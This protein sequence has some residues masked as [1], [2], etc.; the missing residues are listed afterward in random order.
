MTTQAEL[1]EATSKYLTPNHG[2]RLLGMVRGQGSRIWDA[3]GK[4]YLDFFVGFG[5]GGVGGHCHPKIAEAVKAQA[6]TLM[7]HGNFFTS[8]PQV[9]L[10]RRITEHAFGGKVFFCHAGADPWGSSP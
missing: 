6:E 2:R 8:Q 9:D 7:C 3:D 1:I 4:E 5:G 10:A